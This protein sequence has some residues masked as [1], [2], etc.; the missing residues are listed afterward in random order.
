LPAYARLLVGNMARSHNER[1]ELPEEFFVAGYL[2]IMKVMEILKG[3][4]QTGEISDENRGI[5][6]A[7]LDKVNQYEPN[8]W[9]VAEGRRFCASSKKYLGWVPGFAEFGDLICIFK[10]SNVPMFSDVRKAI[11]IS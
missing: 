6:S 10:G 8:V 9:E 11:T 4:Y 3:A 7:S 1:L 2:A 5:L